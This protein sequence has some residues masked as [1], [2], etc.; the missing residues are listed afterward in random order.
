MGGKEIQR[1]NK[2]GKTIRSKFPIEP[3]TS[4]AK[5]ASEIQHGSKKL[6]RASERM[7]MEPVWD[8]AKNK[9]KH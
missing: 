8:Y 7:N 9:R 1:F 3:K 6:Q 4:Y 5:W 2:K